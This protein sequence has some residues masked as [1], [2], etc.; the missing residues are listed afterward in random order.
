MH[1]E[2]FGWFL[3]GGCAIA[4]GVSAQCVPVW[5]NPA[6]G[7]PTVRA[8]PGLV[9]DTAASR[10]L[11]YGGGTSSAYRRDLWQW[12][13]NAWSLIDSGLTSGPGARRGH[14]MAWDSD[15]NAVVVFGGGGVLTSDTWEWAS[16]WAQP[17]T[18]G[19]TPRGFGAMVFDNAL[20]KC[21]M[22]GGWSN[23][24]NY[25]N[26]TSTWD[27]TNWATLPSANP[28]HQRGFHSM[29]YDTA[30]DT[31]VLYGGL[32]NSSTSSNTL[33]DTWEWTGGQWVERTPAHSPGPR[34][35]HSMTY[36]PVGHRVLLYGG[37][38]I[39][40]G[41]YNDTWAWDG[42]DW[43]LLGPAPVVPISRQAQGLAWDT[44]HNNLVMFGGVNGST[45]RND[46]WTATVPNCG[47][48]CD[49]IDFNNDSLFPDT[50]DIDDFL[51][52]FSGGPC[53]TGA[54][55]DIDF[56]N[57]TLFPDTTDIDSLLSVF[58]GGACI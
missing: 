21:V 57:D 54:C 39:S 5:S 28:P 35:Y 58:S 38:E 30:R 27:G 19:P 22:F 6:S 14:M 8:Y 11:M 25:F 13:G 37:W 45:F 52:V 34:A 55:N 4:A 20:H 2:T 9:Y 41:A 42:N 15:R 33:A 46:T 53:S 50:A 1:A 3:V 29:A 24:F 23:G 49:S 16:G 32:W 44:A 26:D 17:P 48:T 56:N 12:N 40:A 43:T 51:S 36:D 7:G 18:T 31:I 10:V 47:P